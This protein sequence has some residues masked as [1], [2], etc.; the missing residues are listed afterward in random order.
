MAKRA[1]YRYIGESPEDWTG[2]LHGWELR[3]TKR[4]D[5]VA[6]SAV[7]RILAEELGA[8]ADAV[9]VRWRAEWAVVSVEE[10]TDQDADAVV[11]PIDAA[12]VKIH[13]VAPLSD[14]IRANARS[15]EDAPVR[16][17]GKAAPDAACDRAMN[18]ARE[19]RATAVAKQQRAT[20]KKGKP[21][22]V[23]LRRAPDFEREEHPARID[24]AFGGSRAVTAGGHA[25]GV[26]RERGGSWALG[27]FP[28]G[29]R[30][31]SLLAP[32]T[33]QQVRLSAH[34]SLDIVLAIKSHAL[35]EIDAA[36]GTWRTLRKPYAFDVEFVADDRLVLVTLESVA[37]CAWSP[38]GE[39][40]VLDELAIDAYR[41]WR[42]SRLPIVIAT[43]ERRSHVIEVAGE[44]LVARG[45]VP[46][47]NISWHDGPAFIWGWECDRGDF[48]LA[49]V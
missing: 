25:V 24:K 44:K 42:S 48:R 5:R 33:G 41:V 36:K 26:F 18:A 38:D 6:R 29:A 35:W 2:Q 31:P 45:D 4:P 40:R 19:R 32:G 22:L 30:R 8:L 47:S 34:P 16:F 11:S 12:L 23:R 27:A 49:N 14:V 1:G 21:A 20:A 13:R 17:R 46:T 28:R 15:I 7:G 3:F 43:H 9:S 37:L 39:L 10:P